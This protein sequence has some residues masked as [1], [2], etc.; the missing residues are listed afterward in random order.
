M[1][2]ILKEEL[3]TVNLDNIWKLHAS[4]S[5]FSC[6]LKH[7]KTGRHTEIINIFRPLYILT[8][9]SNNIDLRLSFENRE[10]AYA[11]FKFDEKISRN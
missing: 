8:Y 2:L 7:K 9:M 6:E 1:D 5:N 4:F 10:S 11:R 3:S